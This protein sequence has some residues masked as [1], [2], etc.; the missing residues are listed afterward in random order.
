VFKKAVSVVALAAAVTFSAGAAHALIID[1]FNTTQSLTASTTG[2]PVS[3]FVASAPTSIVGGEREATLTRLSGADPATLNFNSGASGTL[4]VANGTGG[5]SLSRIVWDGSGDAGA[6]TIDATGLGG[7]DFTV[8]GLQDAFD[9][10]VVAND[11]PAFITIDVYSDALNA[12]TLTI[13]SPGLIPGP[14]SVPLLFE[15]ANFSTLLGSGASFNN[16]GAIVLRINANLNATDIELDFFGTTTTQVPEP[17]PLAALGLGI[18][19]LAFA[20]RRKA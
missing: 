16:V 19:L 20:R 10:R 13:A 14:A 4:S 3:S 2:V 5:T 18:G 15:Y 9:L 17:G 7:I 12:S 6:A 11:F 8:G 1:D